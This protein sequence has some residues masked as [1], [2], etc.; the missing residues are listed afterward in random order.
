[1]KIQY[2]DLYEDKEPEKPGYLLGKPDPEEVDQNEECEIMEI[3][4]SGDESKPECIQLKV[5]TK[6]LVN[7]QSEQ[8]K[9]MHIQKMI[10]N[11]QRSW[12]CCVR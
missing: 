12:G 8:Q 9:Y 3:T 2:F 10:K 1:M 11:T 5:S 6:D 4:H 7:I